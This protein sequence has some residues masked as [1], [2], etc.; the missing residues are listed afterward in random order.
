MGQ[1][2]LLQKLVEARNH[3]MNAEIAL[4]YAFTRWLDR[5]HVPS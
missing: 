1:N 4:L 2:S 3:K 5:L